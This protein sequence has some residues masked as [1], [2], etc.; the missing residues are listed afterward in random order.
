MTNS[1]R[2][3]IL[4]A[5]PAPAPSNG[6]SVKIS[7]I[8]LSL[9]ASA[10]LLLNPCL[11]LADE[12][13]TGSAGG[14]GSNNAASSNS[15]GSTGDSGTPASPAAAGSPSKPLQ[16][17]VQLVEFNLQVLRDLGLDIKEICKSAGS[18]YDEVTIQPV[19]IMTAPEV[20]GHGTIINI[21]IGFTPTGAGPQPKRQRV[22]LAMNRMRPIIQMLKQDIDEF[23]SGHKRLDISEEERQDLRPLFE[24]WIN[25][26]NGISSELTTLEGLTKSPPYDNGAIARSA[27]EIQKDGKKMDDV[28]RKLYKSVQ[29]EGKKKKNA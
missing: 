15:A 22:D 9:A 5:A 27:G 19:T 21:P 18:L 6:L 10:V 2:L 12:V 20:I 8:T 23:L 26:V 25:L 4:P 14:T 3:G 1:L 11:T 16:G 7:K 13:G 17:G 28:R 29:K 24:Q